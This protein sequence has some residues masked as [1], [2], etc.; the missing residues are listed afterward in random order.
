MVF[1]LFMYFNICIINL[2]LKD[3]YIPACD[4]N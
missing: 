2:F 1:A 4:I 3:S